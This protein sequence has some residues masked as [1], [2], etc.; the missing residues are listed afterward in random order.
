[1]SRP[2]ASLVPTIELYIALFAFTQT[3]VFAE[4]ALRI[5]YPKSLSCCRPRSDSILPND[6]LRPSFHTAS[7]LTGPSHACSAPAKTE[8]LMK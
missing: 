2:T 7:P 4:V 5:V 3:T 1:M 6:W 8:I